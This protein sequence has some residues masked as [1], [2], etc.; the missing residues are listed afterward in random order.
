MAQGMAYAPRNMSKES[1]YHRK[2]ANRAMPSLS[3]RKRSSTGVA[4]DAGGDL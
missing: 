3:W 4:S 1:G 2:E